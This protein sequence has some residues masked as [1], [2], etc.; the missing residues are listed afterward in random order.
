MERKAH[1]HQTQGETTEETRETEDLHKDLRIRSRKHPQDF[2]HP[3]FDEIRT[4]LMGFVTKLNPHK[5]KSNLTDA[6]QRGKGWILK[7]I[8]QQKMF[9]TSADKGGATLIL[10]YTTVMDTVRSELEKEP[11]FTKLETSVETK[12][13]QTQQKVK[14]AVL[15][16]HFRG[17]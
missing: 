12:M 6:D 15:K 5:P 9:V 1:F 17:R 4:R 2:N 8:R 16:H 13:E 7:S 14:D 3:L 11:K 10:D